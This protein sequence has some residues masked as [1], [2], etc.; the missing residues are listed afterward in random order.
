MLPAVHRGE[1][2]FV[3][4]PV[5]DAHALAFLVFELLLGGLSPYAH[6][7]GEDSEEGNIRKQFFALAENPVCVP[8]LPVPWLARWRELP[9]PAQ[10]MFTAAFRRGSPARPPVNAWAALLSSTSFPGSWASVAQQ[11]S[12]PSPVKRAILGWPFKRKTA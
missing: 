8:T 3:A 9:L 10:S 5:G 11:P 4:G 2:A 1:E 6:M 7:N 12:P